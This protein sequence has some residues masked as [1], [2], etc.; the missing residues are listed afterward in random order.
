M[1]PF[2]QK[3]LAQQKKIK[4]LSTR[5]F[6]AK[7]LVL[8]QSTP[9]EVITE[10]K[11]AKVRYYAS[12]DRKYKE[13]LVFVAPL[14]INMAIYDLYP[15]RSLVKHFQHSGFDVYLLEWGKLNY[16]DRFLNFL[17]FI[18]DVI[19]HCIDQ[20]CEHADSQYISLHGWS[21]A[22]VFV[23]LYTA[24]HQPE[25]VKN[26]MVMGAPIDS[27]ASGRIGKLFQKTNRLLSRSKNL[28]EKVYT[29]KIPKHFI[30]TPGV[31][32]AIGF[33]IVDPMGW[34]KS[35]KQFL[36]NLDNLHDL[37]EHATMGDFLNHMIDYPGGINQDM[38][39]NVWLQNPLKNGII[40]LKDK[41]I[42]LKN[43]HCPLLIG[44]GSTDQIVTADAASPLG[45]LTSSQDV[46]FT[47]IPGG[48]L[49]LMSSQKSANQFWPTLTQWLTQRSS[50]LK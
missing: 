31:L 25:H 17:S 21:M 9:Y 29:G 33:K 15:Y 43:I 35:Q 5:V 24:L 12:P 45:E 4:H 44:A 19:P 26:L 38:V 48:H 11:H 7:S 20:I 1:H 6:N 14:A 41:V 13:P 28:Q 34:F 32:N 10:Y 2:K 16:Q 36:S 49:G 50:L 37:Y 42:K 46:T 18:D 3:F 39:F 8:S 27:Y 30:H 23:T 40:Q 47:L 22:G